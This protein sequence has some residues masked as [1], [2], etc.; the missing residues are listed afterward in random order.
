MNSLYLVGADRGPDTASTDRNAAL[1]LSGHDR[2]GKRN[3]VVGIVIV[4]AKLMGPK[5]YNLMSG[6]LELRYQL[7]LEFESPMVGCKSYK[8]E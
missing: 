2:M 7:F 4:M 6:S 8:H 1:H 5:V 3:N